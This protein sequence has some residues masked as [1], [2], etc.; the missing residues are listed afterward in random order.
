MPFAGGA[1]ASLAELETRLQ[2]LEA[3]AAMAP[4]NKT[5]VVTGVP[6]NALGQDGDLAADIGDPAGVSTGLFYF[7]SGGTWSS[8]GFQAWKA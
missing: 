5:H 6:D 1:P 3:F 2:Q 8:T 4:F 7:K